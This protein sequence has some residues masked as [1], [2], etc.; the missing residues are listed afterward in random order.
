[1]EMKKSYSP[2]GS[3]P[4]SVDEVL[5]DIQTGRAVYPD[6]DKEADASY[7][8]R[9]NQYKH[10]GFHDVSEDGGGDSGDASSG[11]GGTLVLRVDHIEGSFSNLNEVYDKTWN[12]VSS[13]FENNMRVVVRPATP[14]VII[15]ELPVINVSFENGTYSIVF[16]SPTSETSVG[17]SKLYA[18]SADGYLQ[19]NQCD[20]EGGGGNDPIT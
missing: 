17:V 4:L 12:E 14:P 7:M 5:P 16:L 6:K 15:N 20:S 13:A 18:C 1:M 3:T 9:I 19:S 8:E 10:E 2:F 11:G